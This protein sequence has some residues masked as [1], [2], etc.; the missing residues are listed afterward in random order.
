MPCIGFHYLKTI[1]L[2]IAFCPRTSPTQIGFC[3]LYRATGRENSLLRIL[4]SVLAE[5]KEELSFK[6]LLKKE[7]YLVSK[8]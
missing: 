4:K 7:K 8:Q 5:M 1:R 3:E 2:F 6:L